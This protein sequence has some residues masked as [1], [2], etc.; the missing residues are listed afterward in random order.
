MLDT[1]FLPHNSHLDR[2]AQ[3]EQLDP[4]L[5]RLRR[6]PLIHRFPLIDALP[7]DRPGIYSI[8]GGRQIGKTTLLK[9]WM[10]Q[11]LR[12]GV[13]PDR[14]CY[15]T[16]ELIDDHHSLVRILTD[17]IDGWAPDRAGYALLDEVT[18]IRDWDKGVKFLADAGVFEGVVLMLTGSDTAILREARARFPGRRG[19]SAVV[20]FQAAPLT[21]HEYVRL[22]GSLSPAAASA[23]ADSSAP[24]A[25]RVQ[26]LLDAELERYLR[27]GGYLRAINDL[28]REGSI[29]PSTFATY[30]DWIR[31]DV[32]KRG[33]H[34]HYLREILAA[35]VR[36][37]GS[38]VTWNGLAKDL[39]IDHP[40]TVADYTALLASMDAVFVQPALR[41]DKLSAAPKKPRRIMFS[42]PFIFHA[43][44][45]WLRPDPDAFRNRVTPLLADPERS[46]RLVEACAVT[47]VRRF[48]PTFYIKAEGEVDIAY[49]RRGKLLPVEVKW[50]E[51]LRPR[52]LAQIAKYGNARIWAKTWS[53]NA[54]HGIPVEPLPLALY[55]L[56]PSPLAA[57]Y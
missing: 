19:T 31:G 20:D 22:H 33:K 52:D 51:Q 36:R 56:G 18:Y 8:T 1:R 35:I 23:L 32:L 16:G 12:R 39:S 30:A 28:E 45:N 47:H 41:E 11:L 2:P 17:I 29:A 10:A 46:G 40:M 24:V 49:V 7:H 50:T 37:C 21:F 53:P 34:E 6:E 42:D 54:V 15:V 57:S 5:R 27:H 26:A 14:I 9:Q 43:V 38:Q 48:F 4:D 3:F 44:E 25:P 55:R 13:P